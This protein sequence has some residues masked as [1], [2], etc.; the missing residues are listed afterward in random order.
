M[1]Y[2]FLG[3]IIHSGVAGGG[4]YVSIVKQPDGKFV[5]IKYIDV[6]HVGFASNDDSNHHA[7]ERKVIDFE[8]AVYCEFIKLQFPACYQSK[9]NHQVAI[10]DPTQPMGWSA[11]TG[12]ETATCPF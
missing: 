10:V 5:P 9:W 11:S 6:G 2:S 4:H 3:A 1:W 8:D 7:R 12:L